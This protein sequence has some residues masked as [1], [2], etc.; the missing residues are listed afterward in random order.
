[1][2]N[3]FT[4]I[5][6]TPYQSL[7]TFLSLF[8]TLFLA[9][10]I[11]FLM[12]FLY[13]LLGYVESRP[14]VTIYF[15]TT[16]SEQD[17]LQVKRE[18][19]SS[20]KVSSVTYV[21]KNDAYSIYRNLNKKDPLLMEMI[22]PDI[23]PASLEVFALKPAYLPEISDFLN[24]QTGKDEVTYQK[25]IVD[26]L[27][28]LTSAV[29]KSALIFFAFLVLSTTVILMTITH[30]KVALKKD[31]IEL[32]R[33][34][35]ASGGYVR[36]PFLKEAL[37]FGFTTAGVVFGLFTGILYYL[38]TALGGYFGGMSKLAVSIYTYSLPVWPLNVEIGLV[39]FGFTALFGLSITIIATYLATQ[40]YI[41]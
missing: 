25:N 40:K 5:R 30:F 17:I 28:A 20:G 23:L 11:F 21:S 29:R 3:L 12:S 13:G 9:L 10:A 15:Q 26:R 39:M 19:E 33:L 1:M 6:R 4:T 34:L 18:L 27:L 2:N 31:E 24:R 36:K 35:G 7:A 32:Q 37:F 8:L 41:R 14:Q 16:T 38:Q 22:S